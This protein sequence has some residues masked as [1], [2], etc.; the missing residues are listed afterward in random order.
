MIAYILWHDMAPYP[1]VGPDTRRHEFENGW[2]VM[3]TKNDN[4]SFSATGGHRVRPLPTT[5]HH[6]FDNLMQ[7]NLWLREIAER[8][9]DAEQWLNERPTR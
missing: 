4:G 8:G 3:A 7:L 2:T 6:L 1:A 9:S 5:E